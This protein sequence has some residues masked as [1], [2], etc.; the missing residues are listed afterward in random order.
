M[1]IVSSLRELADALKLAEL[2]QRRDTVREGGNTYSEDDGRRVLP[3]SD[4][5]LDL[6]LSA[7]AADPKLAPLRNAFGGHAV[8]R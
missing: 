4:Y 5:G 1:E 6:A 8:R 7:L 2:L 3:P